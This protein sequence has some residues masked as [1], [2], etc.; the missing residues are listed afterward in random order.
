[1]VN[2]GCIFITALLTCG[3]AG[4]YKKETSLEIP[5]PPSL[6]EIT[7]SRTNETDQVSEKGESVNGETNDDQEIVCRKIVTLGSRIPR[8]ICGTKEQWAVWSNRTGENAKGFMRDAT[9]ASRMNTADPMAPV[10]P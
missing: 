5:T 4:E 1:M 9:E 8:K 3:C 7:A 6:S 10:A 2:L